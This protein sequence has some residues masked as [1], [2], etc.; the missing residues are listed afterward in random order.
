MLIIVGIKHICQKR[1][2]TGQVGVN[3]SAHLQSKEW[4]DEHKLTRNIHLG[5]LLLD[6][7]KSNGL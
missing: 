7:L 6:V 1:V 2:D 3:H 5:S 4:C